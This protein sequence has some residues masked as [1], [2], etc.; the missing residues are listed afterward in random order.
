MRGLFPFFCPVLKQVVCAGGCF[1]MPV[2]D[3]TNGAKEACS[4][5]RTFVHFLINVLRHVAIKAYL[6]LKMVYIKKRFSHISPPPP[7]PPP[8]A[9]LKIWH[10][11]HIEGASV[12][13]VA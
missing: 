6:G 1:N 2:T 4:T 8:P 10:H 5:S 13:T 7:P 9:Q 12:D 11:I 3:R